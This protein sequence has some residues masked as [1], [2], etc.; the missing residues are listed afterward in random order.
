VAEYSAVRE[1]LAYLRNYPINK[2]SNNPIIQF[3][4]D[5]NLVVQQ[6]NGNFKIKDANLQKLAF[7]VRILE[8]ECGGVVTYAYV[9][10]E[11]NTRA[12]YFVNKALDA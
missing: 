9:P 2:L 7:D 1:A 11:E 6:L 3:Y 12:D 4:L 8:K 5:S 10:R